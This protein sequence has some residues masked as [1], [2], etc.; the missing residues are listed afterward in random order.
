MRELPDNNAEEARRWLRNVEYDL[1]AMRALPADETTPGRIVCFLAHLA[2]EKALMATLIDASVPF[3]KTHDLVLLYAMCVE[4]GRLSGID[5]GLLA[6]L[7][8]WAVD[9][10]Y[11]DDLVDADRESATRFASFASDV[12]A[13][14]RSELGEV[15]GGGQ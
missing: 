8:P 14:V 5:S 3:R 12:I 13:A 7:N 10:R 4:A 6:S 11:A 2:I 15:Q 1:R 9:G